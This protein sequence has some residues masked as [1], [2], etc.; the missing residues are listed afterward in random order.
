MSGGTTPPPP[1]AAPAAAAAAGADA[2]DADVPATGTVFNGTN[3]T[4]S[5]TLTGRAGGLDGRRCTSRRRT[6]RAGHEA[7]DRAEST[8]VDDRRAAA[9]DGDVH[10][11]PDR[12]DIGNWQVSSSYAGRDGLP[13][14]STARRAR[15]PCTFAAGPTTA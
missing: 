11:A 8:D 5:G 9:L 2:D 14:A 3:I 4:V 15:S 7:A 13:A 10:D 12:R 6:R 1:P